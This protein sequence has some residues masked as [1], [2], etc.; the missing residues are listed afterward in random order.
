VTDHLDSIIC[1]RPFYA[2]ELNLK[3]D[4]SVC[5][6]AW[7]KGMVGNTRKKSLLEIWND[8][9]IQKMRQMMLEG[10]WQKVCRPGCPYIMD[11][12]ATQQKIHLAGLRQHMLTDEI[13]AAVRSRQTVL[14]TGPTWINFAN[15]NTCNIHCVMCG[16]DRYAD[17][18]ELVQREM[19]QVKALLPGMRE[20]FL[21]GNGDPF[22]RPD[23]RELLLGLDGSRYPDLR[24]NLLTNGLL[25]PRYW[26]RMCH[27]NFGSIDISVDAATAGSYESIRRGATWQDLLRALDHVNRERNRFTRIV[28]NMTVMKENYLEIPAFVE[29]AG[30]YNFGVSISPI[31][32]KWGKQNI[33]TS[34]N[35]GVMEELRGLICAARKRATELKVDFYCSSFNDILSGETTPLVR[36]YRQLV[37]D[38][39][40]QTYYRLKW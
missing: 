26:Q 12:R 19:A 18:G 15:S 38:N 22:A 28:I 14:S 29:L 4:V 1:L 32:G 10:R 6:P 39:L 35:P 21:T 5:C 36:R 25:L 2:L 30:S 27:L 8:K 31:R 33:F 40:V 11:Y 7:S 3:G 16:R 24:L 23:T 37:I 9:P 20:L 13:L 34:A 17:D